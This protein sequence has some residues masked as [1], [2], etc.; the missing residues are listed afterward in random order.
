M[1][2]DPINLVLYVIVGF[3]LAELRR[4]FIAHLERV[5]RLL[6]PQPERGPA[7]IGWCF[8][9]LDGDDALSGAYGFVTETTI[10]GVPWIRVNV[11]DDDDGWDGEVLYRLRDVREFAMADEETCR[12]MAAED[13]A[14]DVTELPPIGGPAVVEDKPN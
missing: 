9:T 8:V 5:E 11:P 1:N 12:E 10:G 2:I 4:A 6:A 13:Q 7:E 3:A 14:D